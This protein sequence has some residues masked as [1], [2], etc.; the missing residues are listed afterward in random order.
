MMFTSTSNG[1]IPEIYTYYIN[2]AID[3]PHFALTQNQNE[4]IQLLSLL[5]RTLYEWLHN[6]FCFICEFH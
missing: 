2:S 4:N 1:I 5:K 6:F 3:I